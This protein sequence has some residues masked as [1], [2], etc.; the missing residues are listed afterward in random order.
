MHRETNP[1][2][3]AIPTCI[4]SLVLTTS[5]GSVNP[6]ATAPAKPPLIKYSGISVAD[7]FVLL[8]FN[9]FFNDSLTAAKIAVC[10]PFANN[11]TGKLR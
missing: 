9:A 3:R 10:G 4:C 2:K 6:A 8:R 11:V 7:V 1:P 5:K